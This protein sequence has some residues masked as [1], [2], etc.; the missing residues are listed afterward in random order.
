MSY[1]D[2]EKRR[3]CDRL[4]HQKRRV[5]AEDDREEVAEVT[6]G[7]DEERGD[8]LKEQIHL[9]CELSQYDPDFIY[10]KSADK[11]GHGESV[12]ATR[13]PADDVHLMS[14]VV[15]DGKTPY[16]T[17]SDFL[18]DCI[19]HRL[20]YWKPKLENCD[21]DQ[22]IARMRAIAETIDIEER[23]ALFGETL[24]K[25]NAM[26]MRYQT[27]D[28]W[29]EALS[30]YKRLVADVSQMSEYWRGKYSQMLQ[31]EFQWALE[32]QTQEKEKR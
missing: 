7:G 32:K 10:T 31:Q 22:T 21:F 3:Q 23:Q 25:L 20:C 18:R 16:K 12:K 4:S 26:L 5:R 14:M 27:D 6:G 17:I 28:A 29:E 19:Y 24:Q 13:L 2:I 30:V 1:G 8:L 11:R 15:D 9:E